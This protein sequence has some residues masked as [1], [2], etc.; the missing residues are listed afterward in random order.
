MKIAIITTLVTVLVTALFG[1]A[2]FIP[3]EAV[4][5]PKETQTIVE[6][7]IKIEGSIEKPR[8]IFIVPKARLWRADITEKD[9]TEELLRP[10]RPNR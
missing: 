1:L 3:S 2:L 7:V 5:Q 8:V 4:G 10:M 9:F 6:R